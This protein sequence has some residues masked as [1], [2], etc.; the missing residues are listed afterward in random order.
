MQFVPPLFFSKGYW[1]CK[2]RRVSRLAL[3]DERVDRPGRESSVELDEKNM[4]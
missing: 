1:L 2:E 3:F 4:G